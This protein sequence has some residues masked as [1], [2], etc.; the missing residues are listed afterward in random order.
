MGVTLVGAA[1]VMIG[2]LV[3]DLLYAAVDPRS[4]GDA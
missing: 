1:A 3:A 2:N 4:R